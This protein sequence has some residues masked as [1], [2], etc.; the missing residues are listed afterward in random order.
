MSRNLAPLATITA[1][2]RALALSDVAASQALPFMEISMAKIAVCLSGHPRTFE[3][4]ALKIKEALGEADFY[5][6]TWTSD[7]NEKLLDVFSTHQF[8]LV[9]Y[10]FIS[11]PLQLENER[12]IISDFQ[13]S[14]PDFFILNQW[15]GVKRAIQLM[16]DYSEALQ[17]KYDIVIRCRFDLDCRFTTEQL[18]ECYKPDALNFVKASAG[19]ADQLLF[20]TPEVMDKFLTFEA[21]LRGFAKKFGSRYG[22]FASPLLRAYFLDLAIPLN[23]ASLDMRVMREDRSS[24][25]MAREKRTKDYIAKHFPEFDGVAWADVRN[26]DHVLKPGPWDESFGNNKDMIYVD[27]KKN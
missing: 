20:G 3:R 7:Y 6:S 1:L 4:A 18:I 8:N 26:V 14:Y 11:E 24:P 25:S 12:A 10:E 15:F 22:F 13:D 2:C 17:K 9:A 19:G 5:F 27:G 16:R 23:K 21:W